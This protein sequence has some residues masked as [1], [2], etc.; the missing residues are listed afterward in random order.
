VSASLGIARQ[1]ASQPQALAA[2]DS[3]REQLRVALGK[4]R[5]LG[6]DLYPVL[7]DSEG[8]TAALESLADGSPL[9]VDVVSTT[10]RQDPEA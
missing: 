7:L 1:A 10:G 9:D 3:A 6:R 8:L 2:I 4:A 5:G